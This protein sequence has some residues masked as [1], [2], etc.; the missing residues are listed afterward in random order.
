M[1]YE[2][3]LDI[4]RKRI[5]IGALCLLAGGISIGALLVKYYKNKKP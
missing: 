5:R 3:R 4:M 1:T 2:Q